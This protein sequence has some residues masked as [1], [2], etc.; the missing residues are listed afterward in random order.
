M[1]AFLSAFFDK[2]VQGSSQSLSL[3]LLDSF[4]GVYVPG[5]VKPYVCKVCGARYK[6]F[7][8]L[9]DHR[10][11]HT[12]ETICDLN[13]PLGIRRGI[14]QTRRDSGE[15]QHACETCGARYK[16]YRSLLDHRKS[17]TSA[18]YCSE[19]GKNLSTSSN[20]RIHMRMT[21]GISI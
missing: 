18:T 11:A 15:K 13:P 8:S 14:N 6:N 17:H 10:K 19:C 7:R 9:R 2:E 4:E 20:F 5:E 3:H 1:T 12:S 21:H 16:H